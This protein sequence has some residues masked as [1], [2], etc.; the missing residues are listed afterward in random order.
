MELNFQQES[1]P[2]NSLFRFLYPV[3][4][5]TLVKTGSEEL[6]EMN[7][8]DVLNTKKAPAFPGRNRPQT[9]PRRRQGTPSP[10][11]NGRPVGHAGGKTIQG[12]EVARCTQDP[13]NHA[14]Q[15]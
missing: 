1:I 7:M 5:Y 2:A 8:E 6:V 15:R 9:T 14:K 10:E 4:L 12:S 11:G 13:Q 3:W